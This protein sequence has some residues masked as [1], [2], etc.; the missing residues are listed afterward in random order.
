M[1]TGKTY[2]L[3]G[4][5]IS[6]HNAIMLSEHNAAGQLLNTHILDNTC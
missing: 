6:T 4:K 1:T 3:F 5:V 2:F